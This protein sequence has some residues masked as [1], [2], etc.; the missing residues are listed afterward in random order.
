MTPP[1]ALNVKGKKYL[2]DGKTYNSE[3]E[4]VGISKS[5][6]KEGF[7]IHI[8][9]QENEYMVYSRRVAAVQEST[10]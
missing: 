10:D 7:D 5:Y 9:E 8:F 2:W 1:L 3:D 6:E 4:A